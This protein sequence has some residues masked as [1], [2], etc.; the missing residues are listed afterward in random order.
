MSSVAEPFQR[1]ELHL[2]LAVVLHLA[3]GLIIYAIVVAADRKPHAVMLEGLPIVFGKMI[4]PGEQDGDAPKMLAKSEPSQAQGTAPETAAQAAATPKLE[5]K[6]VTA[7]AATPAT[8]QA[9]AVAAAKPPVTPEVRPAQPLVSK[10]QSRPPAAVALDSPVGKQTPAAN[11]PALRLKPDPEE[12]ER[13]PPPVDAAATRTAEAVTQEP[14]K[15]VPPV[16]EKAAEDATA[17]LANVPGV[18]PAIVPQLDARQRVVVPPKPVEREAEQAK[19]QK[20]KLAEAKRAEEAK[21][22]EAAAAQAKTPVVPKE[23]TPPAVTPPKAPEST[24][25]A[26]QAKA[27]AATTAPP[28]PAQAQTPPVVTAAQPKPPQTQASVAVPQTETPDTETMNGK[29]SSGAAPI[30]RQKAEEPQRA[31]AESGGQ[32]QAATP[33]ETA[34]PSGSG[35]AAKAGGGS[36]TAADALRRASEALS[37]RLGGLGKGTSGVPSGTSLT[38]SQLSQ[39]SKL[40]QACLEQRQVFKFGDKISTTFNVRIDR[41]QRRLF[42]P[43]G[44][45]ISSGDRLSGPRLR[46]ISLALDKCDSFKKFVLDLPDVTTFSFK[47]ASG[48]Q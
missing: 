43:P 22:A 32:Q 39:G 23:V 10:E 2:F 35:T 13:T 9:S 3:V 5:Q 47:F 28:P 8:P 1:D 6:P 14:K 29:Q 7:K 26:D 36:Q 11:L 34:K 30:P 4:T 25:K 44:N 21:A 24:Q 19:D 46:E 16:A 31:P 41:G 37:G 33:E 20:V 27:A 40:A 18:K 38:G 15:S 12:A 42:L 48:L 45:E 17:K